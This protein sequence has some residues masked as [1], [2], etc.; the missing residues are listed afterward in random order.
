MELKPKE[1][2]GASISWF[3]R[4]PGEPNSTEMLF[5]GLL[6]LSTPHERSLDDWAT[7]IMRYAPRYV[8]EGPA[9]LPDEWKVSVKVKIPDIYEPLAKA[10]AQSQWETP[11]LQ[12][13]A[14]AIHQSITDDGFKLNLD[15][16]RLRDHYSWQTKDKKVQSSKHPCKIRWRCPVALI[17]VAQL[18]M[19]K[20][21]DMEQLLNMETVLQKPTH[22]ETI[23]LHRKTLDELTEN[24]EALLR[25]NDVIRKHLARKA[26]EKAAAKKNLSDTKAAAKQQVKD[27]KTAAAKKYAERLTEERE[28]RKQTRT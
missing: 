2:R 23:T 19:H 1:P 4:E 9:G 13:I 17:G 26:E 25:A 27:A 7:R 15:P 21:R 3:Q 28:K 16:Q 20:R 14:D 18:I 22:E 24:K 10:Y 12:R 11:M 6:V 5:F 8:S